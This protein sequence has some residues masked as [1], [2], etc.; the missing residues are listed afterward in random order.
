MKYFFRKPNKE[1]AD[2]SLGIRIA[3]E[4]KYVRV[5]IA[6]RTLRFSNTNPEQFLCDYRA[7]LS[8]IKLNFE[9]AVQESN[10]LMFS[11]LEREELMSDVALH[12]MRFHLTVGNSVQ[13]SP[14]DLSHPQTW[15]IVLTKAEEKYG[16]QSA[17]AMALAAH[18]LSLTVERLATWRS[19]EDDRMSMM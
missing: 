5:T 15:D 7:C 10:I 9:P 14:S 2:E 12:W 6:D 17:E 8:A 13:I 3:S 18:T 1:I 16:K 4:G 19:V 11:D